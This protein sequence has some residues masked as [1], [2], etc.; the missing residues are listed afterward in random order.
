[1][2]ITHVVDR[3]MGDYESLPRDE[4]ASSTAA[5]SKSVEGWILLITGLH[6]ETAEEDLLERFGEFGTVQGLHLNLDRR[7][8][9]VKVCIMCHRCDGIWNFNAA[10]VHM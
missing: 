6:E 1:M 4:A 2:E 9:F 5:G 8:G 7:T 10:L 3:K